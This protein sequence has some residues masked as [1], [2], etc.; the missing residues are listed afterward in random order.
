M[1]LPVLYKSVWDYV[2]HPTIVGAATVSKEI[3]TGTDPKSAVL[4]RSVSDMI[5]ANYKI[6]LE[7]LVARGY[8]K[9][10]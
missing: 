2:P 3:T 8:L 10:A 7:K 6:I 1:N 5:S 4:I 9:K